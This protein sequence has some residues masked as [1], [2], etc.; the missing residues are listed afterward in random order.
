MKK[1][2]S[3]IVLIL[4]AGY[5]AVALI[6]F[7]NKPS[8]QL[9]GNVRLEMRDSLNTGYMT[10]RDII[11]LLEKRNLNPVGRRLDEVNLRDIEEALEASPIIRNCECYKT[12]NGDVVVDIECRRP[13]L[14]VMA[15]AGESYYLDEEGEVIE[16]VAKA[17]YIPVAT[18]RIT[19]EFAQKELLAL[20]QFLQED[21]WWN[22][23]IEQIYVTPRQGIELIPRVGGHVIELGR[24]GDYEQKFDRLKVF[25]EKGLGEVGWDRYSRINVDYE[26]QVVATK[27]K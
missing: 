7:C 20:A 5:V 22:A 6:A 19:R 1:V 17:I 12:I 27:K 13:I 10:T 15:D 26:N 25:Y 23:Q 14:R 16:H 9:C 18:G 3:T 21:D 8:E 4:L 24:P 2:L 11:A